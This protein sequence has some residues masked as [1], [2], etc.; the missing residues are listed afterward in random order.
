MSAKSFK[1]SNVLSLSVLLGAL[2]LA[3]CSGKGDTDWPEMKADETWQYMQQLRD[4]PV[5]PDEGAESTR[6]E[7]ASLPPAGDTT[8]LSAEQV[9]AQLIVMEGRFEGL[10]SE[11]SEFTRELGQALKKTRES[12]DEIRRAEL[13][14]GSQMTLS[15][16]ADRQVSLG[17]LVE[18][19]FSLQNRLPEMSGLEE[20]LQVLQQRARSLSARTREL[21]GTAEEQLADLKQ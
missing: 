20:R 5:T 18:D 14:R 12:E 10:E 8:P 11:I 15:R 7:A 4:K 6:E 3:A 9:Q 17:I 19:A 1:T 16:L 2:G 21:I 13:W